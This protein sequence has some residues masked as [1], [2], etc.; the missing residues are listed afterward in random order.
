[1]RVRADGA[2]K[3]VLALAY[4]QC[5]IESPEVMF[6]F[7]AMA[8]LSTLSLVLVDQSLGWEYAVANAITFLAYAIAAIVVMRRRVPPA[9]APSITAVAFALAVLVMAWE[10]PLI[11]AGALGGSVLLLAI[12]GAIVL[13]WPPF[14][15][16][17]AVMMVAMAPRALAEQEQTGI[18][19]LGIQG[20]AL[21]VSAVLL[22]VRRRALLRLATANETIEHLATHDQLTG[23]LNRHGLE[24]ALPLLTGMARRDGQPIFTVFVDVTGLKGVN[25]THGHLAGDAV[26]KATARAVAAVSRDADLVSRWG[27]DE[28]LVVGIGEAP[29]A[30]V[31]RDRILAVI[32]VTEIDGWWVPGVGVGAASCNRL[33]RW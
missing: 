8:G 18:S 22:W 17:G 30:S 10:Y 21:F 26:I 4:D 9:W 3:R 5:R 14:L 31:L 25:D 7:A 20:S 28:F 23:L 15:I 24:T 16:A 27:G 33:T 6:V 13:T 19:W 29:D 12:Y 1:M 2:S 32:D 11:G